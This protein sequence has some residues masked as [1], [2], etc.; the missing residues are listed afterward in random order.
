MPW[1]R[2]I[3]AA[4]AVVA[5]LA[6]LVLDLGLYRPRSARLNRLQGDLAVTRAS[7]AQ[8]LTAGSQSDSLRFL[9]EQIHGGRAEQ[10][11]SGEDPLQMVNRLVG[12]GRVR[13]LAVR[14]GEPEPGEFHVQTPVRIELEG[15]YGSILRFLRQIESPRTPAVIRE[16]QLVED[17][18]TSGYRRMHLVLVSLQPKDGA[19]E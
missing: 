18:E 7:L 9:M 4:G 8:V 10:A 2:C 17:A 1:R 6:A 14:P 15:S 3:A 16:F 12:S 13:L 5:L 11:M 19:R